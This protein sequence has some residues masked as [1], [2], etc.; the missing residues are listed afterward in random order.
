[1]PASEKTITEV[2]I[3]IRRHVED[4]TLRK[5]VKDLLDVQGNKSFRDTILKLA[6]GL[7]VD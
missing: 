4:D 2:L 3:V 1:M 5:I 7:G 6:Q